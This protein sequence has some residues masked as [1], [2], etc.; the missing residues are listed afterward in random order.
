MDLKKI[1]GLDKEPEPVTEAR[2]GTSEAEVKEYENRK[3]IMLRMH[4]L[5]TTLCRMN[6]KASNHRPACKAMKKDIEHLEKV[7]L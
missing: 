6:C 5:R 1:F 3:S 2:L 7:I 4:H